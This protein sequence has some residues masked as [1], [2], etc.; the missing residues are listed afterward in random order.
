MASFSRTSGV[1]ILL[2]GVA[3]V[4][5]ATEN[6]R[7]RRHAVSP[8]LHPEISLPHSEEF[9]LYHNSLSLCS[10]KSR[11]C[12]EELQ[13]PY[14]SHPIDLIETGAYENIRA[15]FLAVNPGGTVPVLVHQGH[16]VYESHEQIRYASRFASEGSPSLVPDDPGLRAEM[17]KW[18]DLSS[19]TDDPINNGHLSVGNAVPGQT[20]PLFA[21]M[22]E[23]IPY[24]KIAEGLLFHFDKYRPLVFVAMKIRGIEK[25]QAI[26]P[27]VAVIAKSR[28]QMHGHFDALEEQLDRSKGPWLLGDPYTLADVS[29][30]VIFERLRQTDALEVFASETRR[31]ATFAYWN[32]LAA[33]PAYR[34]AILDRSHPLI[35]YGRNRIVEAKAASEKLRSCLEGD[36]FDAS[37]PRME[38]QE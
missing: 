36:D 14:K 10:M 23:K 13:I 9:E 30:L 38:P 26:A 33:R 1:L 34:T 17:E 20:L 19:L 11:L 7:R 18:I 8:G 12:L 6:R 3:L 22:I 24:W 4:A 15:P 37:D 2:T 31:P 21:A 5:W 35:E 29:W 28:R 25:I 32:R 27:M 16:P